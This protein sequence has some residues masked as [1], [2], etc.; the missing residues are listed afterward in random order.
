MRRKDREKDV[1]SAKNV[2]DSSLYAVLS[3]VSPEGKP[4]SIPISPARDGD[5][6]Y[7]HSA[8]EGTKNTYLENSAAV[9]LCFVS[10]ASLYAKDFSCNYR[11]AV[12]K[13]KAVLVASD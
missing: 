2:I 9:S 11:S 7:F 8:K 13:G 3:L 10:E 6:L 12:V 5:V 4:Y 1:E